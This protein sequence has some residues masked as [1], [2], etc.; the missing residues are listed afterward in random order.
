[1]KSFESDEIYCYFRLPISIAIPWSKQL[2]LALFLHI[3]ISLTK[4]IMILLI[5]DTVQ[6]FNLTRN[7]QEYSA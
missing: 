4:T 2:K 1:M 6:L 3:I 7:L 5:D